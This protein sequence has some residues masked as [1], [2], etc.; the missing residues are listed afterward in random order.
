MSIPIIIVIISY[1]IAVGIRIAINVQPKPPY[2]QTFFPMA[3]VIDNVL[4]LCTFCFIQHTQHIERHPR[5][6][7]QMPACHINRQMM[8]TY[9]RNVQC[10]SIL[11]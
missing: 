7:N 10:I 6:A 4:M 8:G 9:N 1:T 2:A 3:D 11:N 5:F